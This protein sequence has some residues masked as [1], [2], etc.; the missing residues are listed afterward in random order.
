MAVC[1][2]FELLGVGVNWFVSSG[3]VDRGA[4]YSFSAKCS[5]HSGGQ[6]GWVVASQSVLYRHL[7]CYLLQP[8]AI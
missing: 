1:F 5:A 6:Y 2:G 3:C 4:C 8:F 7:F